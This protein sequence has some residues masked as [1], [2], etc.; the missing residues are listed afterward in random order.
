MLIIEYNKYYKNMANLVF[1]SKHL[2]IKQIMSIINLLIF[3][4]LSFN[5]SVIN[6]T[7]TLVIHHGFYSLMF[8]GGCMNSLFAS[9]FISRSIGSIIAFLSCAVLINY[10]SISI[11]YFGLMFL[12][13]IMKVGLQIYEIQCEKNSEKFN[14]SKFKNGMM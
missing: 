5:L 8:Y 14:L 11:I 12:H 1:F 13:F 2:L 4:V 7:L 9:D 10:G 3:V 6:P